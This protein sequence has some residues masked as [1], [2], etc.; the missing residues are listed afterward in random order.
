MTT[1]SVIHF[2]GPPVSGAMTAMRQ[3]LG[4]NNAAVD[5]DHECRLEQKLV[6]LRCHRQLRQYYFPEGEPGIPLA[7][8]DALQSLKACSGVVFTV[9]SQLERA[10]AN[11]AWL[12][13]LRSML[14]KS[15][16]SLDHLPV[17]FFCNKRDLPGVVPFEELRTS[18]K[19]ARCQHFETTATSGSGCEAGLRWLVGQV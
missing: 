5:I 17:A 19:T 14:A 6:F 7:Y 9:D 18:V 8:V 2:W 1:T 10:E 4:R 16:M 3:L 13:R 15:E 12:G 11:V